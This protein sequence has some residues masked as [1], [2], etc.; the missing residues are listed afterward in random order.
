MEIKKKKSLKSVMV[1]NYDWLVDFN[2]VSIS[3]GLFPVYK[4]GNYVCYVFIF[5]FVV[6]LFL[7][8]F[9]LNENTNN[10]LTDLFDLYMGLYQVLPL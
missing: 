10:F 5:T 7:K 2:G 4:F 9:F 1:L 8:C 3:L 6:Q